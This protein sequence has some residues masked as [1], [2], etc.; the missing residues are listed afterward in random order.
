VKTFDYVNL[1]SLN[2]TYHSG[3]VTANAPGKTRI[4]VDGKFTM[5]LEQQ[6]WYKLVPELHHDPHFPPSLGTWEAP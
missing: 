5:V 3:Y 4:L 1:R 2:G 6:S